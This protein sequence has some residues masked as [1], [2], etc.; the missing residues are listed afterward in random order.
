MTRTLKTVKTSEQRSWRGRPET[1]SRSEPAALVSHTVTPTARARTTRSSVN[2]RSV[3]R[4]EA[5]PAIA[6]IP[7]EAPATP[8]ATAAPAA[9]PDRLSVRAENVLKELAVELVGES[10]PKGRWIPSDKLLQKLKF[11]HLMTARN[12]GPHTVDEVVQWAAGRGVII[13]RPFYVGKSLSTMW[14]DVIEKFSS[15]DFTKAEIIEALERSMRR[16]NTKIPVAVQ[17]ILLQ[18]LS[19]GN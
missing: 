4:P 1:D 3:A 12:C 16:S 15:G 19:S 13:Q 10:P 5:A 18:L 7:A 17:G 14:R 8:L 6:R 11:K 9:E 2:A